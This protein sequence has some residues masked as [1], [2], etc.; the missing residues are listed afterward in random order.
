MAAASTESYP[1]LHIFKYGQVTPVTIWHN[2]NTDEKVDLLTSLFNGIRWS[3]TGEMK[4]A[5]SEKVDS[6]WYQYFLEEVS[7]LPEFDEILHKT[8]IANSGDPWFPIDQHRILVNITLENART[9]VAKNFDM[10]NEMAPH[11][12]SFSHNV[13]EVFFVDHT[14][15]IFAKSLHYTG[16]FITK[17]GSEVHITWDKQFNLKKIEKTLIALR[18]PHKKNVLTQ[19]EYHNLMS[20]TAVSMGAMIY[21]R[22]PTYDFKTL[23]IG[24]DKM[25]IPINHD[26]VDAL[27]LSI[28]HNINYT[29]CCAVCMKKG[30]LK[31]CRCQRAFYCGAV[32][33]RADWANHKKICSARTKNAN[34][35]HRL[36]D[37]PAPSP[38]EV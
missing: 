8:L 12:W 29:I 36:V 6:L 26:D 19:E 3:Y 37:E 22:L 2:S 21:T 13:N 11:W 38:S 17:R 28:L 5:E 32:C 10:V 15:R 18:I 31:R 16:G 24:F 33:Q 23:P 27:T 34:P 9:I 1:E 35:T 7:K 30:E 20:V 14:K 4:T 25:I